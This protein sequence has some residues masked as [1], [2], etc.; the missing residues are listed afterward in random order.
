[1]TRRPLAAATLALSL[2]APAAS[3]AELAPT[4]EAALVV[5]TTAGGGMDTWIADLTAAGWAPVPPEGAMAAAMAL[6]PAELVF[7]FMFG[8]D[9][10]WEPARA[11]QMQEHAAEKWSRRFSRNQPGLAVLSTPAGEVVMLGQGLPDLP[12]P[13]CRLA[14]PGATGA[15]IAAR[16]G[17]GTR[18]RTNPP[19]TVTTFDTGEAA[20]RWAVGVAEFAPH[21]FG[22][23][24]TPP[25]VMIS[26]AQ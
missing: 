9:E 15:V 12:V 13:A 16:F 25:V 5:C 22:T 18:V 6:A 1:M 7:V 3:L 19:L 8:F 2:A 26:P 17:A 14:L 23:P 24:Q 20:P 11:A 4:A 21:A 10:T